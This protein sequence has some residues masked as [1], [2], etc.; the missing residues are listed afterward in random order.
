MKSHSDRLQFLVTR[1]YLA[2]FI[3]PSIASLNFV[4]FFV[5]WFFLLKLIQYAINLF[6]VSQ[7]SQIRFD[8]WNKSGAVI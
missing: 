8:E 1:N 6:L 4:T 3:L 2:I 5:S 7:A